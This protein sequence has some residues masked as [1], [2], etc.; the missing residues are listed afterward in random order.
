MNID[1]LFLRAIYKF[2]EDNNQRTIQ[3]EDVVKSCFEIFPETFSFEKYT[4]WP[5]SGKIHFCVRRCRDQHNW[6]VGSVRTG[7]TLTEIGKTMGSVKIEN[8]FYTDIEKRKKGSGTDSK[9]LNYIGE[10]P[11]YKR[12]LKNPKS[13]TLSESELRDIL[14]ST[15]ETDYKTLSRNL[16]YLIKIIQDYGKEELIDFSKKIKEKLGEIKEDE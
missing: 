12:Y 5:D 7:F 14:K 9:L 2:L 8:K 4:Q 6:L 1:R 13:F 10:H 11:L 16:D 3:W 15:M